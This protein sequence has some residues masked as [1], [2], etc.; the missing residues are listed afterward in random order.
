MSLINTFYQTLED[1]LNEILTDEHIFATSCHEQY[2]NR[3]SVSPV[4]VTIMNPYTICGNMILTI[5][6]SIDDPKGFLEKLNTFFMD[7]MSL[8]NGYSARIIGIEPCQ[9]SLNCGMMT[10]HISCAWSVWHHDHGTPWGIKI[11]VQDEDIIKKH[12]S[13]YFISYQFE[14]HNTD[15]KRDIN[16]NMMNTTK[17]R[18]LST[19]FVELKGVRPYFDTLNLSEKT[20]RICFQ[21]HEIPMRFISLA[22][23]KNKDYFC[24]TKLTFESISTSSL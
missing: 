9:T 12:C 18:Y 23:Q 7:D 5:S 15:I 24:I 3:V 11:L 17:D 21:N 16:N 1:Q 19:L 2:K 4:S 22:T 13:G 20:V 10:H 6:E 14:K 8:E